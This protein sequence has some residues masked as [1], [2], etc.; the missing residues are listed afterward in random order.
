MAVIFVVDDEEKISKL[1][2][3]QLDD[4]GHTAYGMTR[5]SEALEKLSRISPDIVVTDLRMDEMDGI[6]LLKKVKKTS[7][8]TDVVVMTAYATVE[9]ALDTM[10]HGAYDYIIKPFTT[11]E[12]LMLIER[13][14][15][16][17]R[18]ETENSELRS[19]LA[20]GMED[21]IIG[22]S[23]AIGGVK[24]LIGDVAQS[25]APVLIRGESGTGKEL[26]A[27]AIHKTSPRASG[28]FIAINCAAIPASLVESELFGYEKGAFTGATGRKLGHFQ[29]ADGG[30][31]FLD[32]IGDLPLTLQSKLLR[33]LEDHKVTP[34]GAEKPTEV[35]L[36]L[37]SA[38]N[39]P[40]E[41]EIR[42]G[43]F[44]EDLYYRIN[45]F[46]IELPPLRDR[47]EDIRDIARHFIGKAGR[48]PADLS[49]PAVRKLL[50][51]LWPGNIRELR[52]VV[53]R[54]LIVRANG[55]ITAD[56]ILLLNATGPKDDQQ[57]E[58]LNLEEMEKRLVSKAL[59]ITT[60]N[61]SEAARLLGI[62][63]RAVYGR[64]ERYG[65]EGE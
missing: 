58:G 21:E 63:R 23:E 53:E 29:M 48:D 9:T 61:K 38:T 37:L 25:D 42:S 44:R 33:V 28:P 2:K 49:E 8:E 40:L 24:K 15:K 6:T 17:R 4:A 14:E 20:A 55:I 60:G 10:K 5:P 43:G 7:P 57:P 54:A 65:M 36:R 34:L 1:L 52:N 3:A 62:T 51:Y 35:D 30:T 19:Y 32:E 13:I 41:E 47:P 22:E 31:L 12:L 64:L 39:Q 46:P 59:K 56:D 27:R 50:S 45:V 16:K 18:L 11:D 26:V